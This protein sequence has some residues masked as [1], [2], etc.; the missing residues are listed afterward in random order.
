MPC[1]DLNPQGTEGDG[2][3]AGQE[4]RLRSQGSQGQARTHWSLCQLWLLQEGPNQIPYE[5]VTGTNR[6]VACSRASITT[7]SFWS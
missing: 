5:G 6:H 1:L 3:P 4:H 2:C 7:C